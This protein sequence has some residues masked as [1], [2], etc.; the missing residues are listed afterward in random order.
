MTTG[1]TTILVGDVRERLSD[2][3]TASAQCC[4]TSPPFW[5]LRDY[6]QDGQLGLEATPEE[7]VANMVEVFCEV[8]RVLR[9]DGTLWLNL[10]DSYASAWACAR[11]NVVGAGSLESGK[12]AD[13]PNRLVS[14]LKEKDLVGIPWMVAFALRAEGWYLRRDIIWSKPNPMPESVTDRPTSAHEYLFLFTKSGSPTFWTHRD[15]GGSRRRPEPDYRW[16]HPNTGEESAEPKPKPWRRIN[17]WRSHDY[18]Y[19]ADAIRETAS[20]AHRKP[21]AGWASGDTPHDAVLGRNKRSVWEIATRPYPDAHFAT[22]PPDLPKP[23]ILAGTPPMSCGKCGSPWRRVIEREAAERKVGP[24]TQARQEEAEARGLGDGLRTGF[25]GCA[26][27]STAPMIRTIGWEPT[28]E[29]DD[30]SG[31]ALV[32]D[33]FSG[34][35]TVGLVAVQLGRDYIGIELNPEYVRIGEDR[36]ARWRANP[37]GT[38][39]GDPAP[40]PGQLGMEI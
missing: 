15:S 22:F 8:R 24:K 33:P 7:Y 14:G 26:D 34:A 21:P 25:S 10:G 3:A 4:V 40:L 11:R 36:I 39:T 20:N 18:F 23:C 29:H 1:E 31:R 28:C 27:G 12:R 13:R 5:G 6:G 17:L 37:A 19:D 32:L 30:D 35:A 16:V 9:D 2:L 38:L